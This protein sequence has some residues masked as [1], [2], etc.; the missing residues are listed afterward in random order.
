MFS[1]NFIV[2]AWVRYLLSSIVWLNL[3]VLFVAG[4]IEDYYPYVFGKIFFAHMDVPPKPP[5]SGV[6]AQDFE[7]LGCQ[8]SWF[9]CTS[10]GIH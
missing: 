3:H 5:G 2:H 1:G 4:N 8:S 10:A 9:W 6:L 7:Y